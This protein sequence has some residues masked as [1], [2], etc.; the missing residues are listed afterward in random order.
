METFDWTF[1]PHRFA[2]PFRRLGE[3]PEVLL[4]SALSTTSTQRE[5]Y[6]LADELRK[7]FSVYT[8]DWPGFGRAS[9][10]P[11][12][13]FSISSIPRGLSC[14]SCTGGTSTAT[15]GM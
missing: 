4:L 14:S 10:P 15:P 2:I 8:V 11:S 6:P 12:D 3:G 13:R 5:M 1:G 7:S 9:R